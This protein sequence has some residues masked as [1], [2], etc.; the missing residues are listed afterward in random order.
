MV[1]PVRESAP[2][3]IGNSIPDGMDEVDFVLAEIGV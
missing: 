1:E 2:S 3:K